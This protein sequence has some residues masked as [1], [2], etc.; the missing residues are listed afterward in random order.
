MEQFDICCV[1]SSDNQ[2]H[3]SSYQSS[4]IT[5]NSTTSTAALH[6]EDAIAVIRDIAEG[7]SGL[8]PEEEAFAPADL[9]AS[10]EDNE[11]IGSNDFTTTTYS[12]HVTAIE[13]ACTYPTIQDYLTKPPSIELESAQPGTS[14]QFASPMSV[15]PYWGEV[16]PSLDTH[17]NRYLST[18]PAS[19]QSNLAPYSSPYY[20]RS[21]S[22]SPSLIAGLSPSSPSYKFQRTVISPYG[23]NSRLSTKNYIFNYPKISRKSRKHFMFSACEYSHIK[24]GYCVK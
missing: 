4:V 9:M 2:L 15:A 17:Q 21:A 16:S 8:L 6:L 3:L 18:Y 14:Q 24:V 20:G 1:M 5:N 13:T 19:P 10:E 11:N 22:V 23:I 7:E 12:S